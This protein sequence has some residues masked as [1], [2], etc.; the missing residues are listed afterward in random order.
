MKILEI[1]GL[2]YYYPILSDSFK[3]QINSV[4]AVENIDLTIRRG[5]C[6]GIVGESGCGKTTLGKTI[7]RLFR[8]TD[9]KIVFYHKNQKNVDISVLSQKELK[10]NRIRAKLQMIFPNSFTSFNPKM[11]VKD[12]ITEPILLS[13]K[14]SKKELEK[15]ALSLLKIVELDNSYLNKHPHNFSGGHR[16]RIAITRA[17]ATNPELIV[18]DEPT[19]ALNVFGQTQILNL[20]Q[21]LHKRFNLTFLFFTQHLPVAKYIS[22][23]IAVM[24]LGKIIEI[25]KTNEFFNNPIHPYT[26][27]LLS[28]VSAAY[29]K[30][31][32]KIVLERDVPN[33]INPPRGCKFHTHCPFCLD[34]C[35][36]TE[37]PLGFFGKEHKVACHRKIEIKKLVKKRFGV[38][39]TKPKVKKTKLKRIR[40]KATKASQNKKNK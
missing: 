36:K 11:L 39:F 31:G 32:K 30:I 3:K 38:S 17:I 9:G 40:N 2:K 14:I 18:L 35:V 27:T 16:Q 25:A 1:K 8:P 19:S 34:K 23:R 20:L 10:K 5:E 29:K 22:D 24:Y 37:P 12:I 13:K 15:K 28:G 6:L 26:I 21:D 33:P 7:I 4:K